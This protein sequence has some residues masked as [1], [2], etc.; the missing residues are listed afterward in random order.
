MVVELPTDEADPRTRL[1]RMS[2]TMASAKERHKA[3]PASILQDANH[4]IPPALLARAAR[5][6]ARIAVTRGL[7]APLN[8]IIS[9]V[10]GS[11]LP[12]YLA[13]AKLEAQ[14]PI[15]AVIDGSGLNITLLSYRDQLDFGVVSDPSMLD[16]AFDIVARLQA[17]L[18]ELVALIPAGPPKRR[19]QRLGRQEGRQGRRRRLSDA[20]WHPGGMTSSEPSVTGGCLCGG[21]R[22]ELTE[23]ADVTPATAT[24]PAASGAPARRVVRAGADRRAHVPLAQRGGAGPG[25]A[26][27]G[28]RLREVL[29]PRV[30][31]APV[32][33]QPRRPDA[34]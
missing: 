13:G 15:S 5:V 18:E 10:P 16:D 34:R 21:V 22:F 1:D 31:R 8:L 19:D 3:M 2:S 25:L 17:A 33:P 14:Y 24:A 23:P 26:P 28:R 6:T 29:L 7:E 20:G 11:P 27:S 12:L 9:N 30:R 32:Q 4:V